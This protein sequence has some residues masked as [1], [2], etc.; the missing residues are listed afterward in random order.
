MSHYQGD[1]SEQDINFHTNPNNVINPDEV[2]SPLLTDTQNSSGLRYG[3]IP[4]RQP[5]RY[6]TTKKIKLSEGN[7]VIDCPVPSKL[8][9]MVP[10]KNEDE[11]TQMRYTACTCDPNQ[12]IE[13][14]YA[15]RQKQFYSPPRSTELFI[16]LTMYNVI[17]YPIT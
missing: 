7:F 2:S 11:F 15:L 5:R 14:R 1:Y 4:M 10:R 6:K 17:K 3:D 13:Q 12:F 16:V 9:S 8:L